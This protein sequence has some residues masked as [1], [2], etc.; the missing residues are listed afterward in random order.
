MRPKLFI[1]AA[2]AV[3]CVLAVSA[4]CEPVEV[5]YGAH[6]QQKLDV[7]VAYPGA[8][9]VVMVH[10]GGFARGDK[11][12][13]YGTM[14]YEHIREVLLAHGFS[15]V[16]VNYRLAADILGSP[17]QHPY[18]FKYPTAHND[19][20]EAVEWVHANGPAYGLSWPVGVVGESA[21]GNLGA[22]LAVTAKTEA[23]AYFDIGGY[24]MLA[25]ASAPVVLQ[26]A[27]NYLGCP[28]DVCPKLWDEASPAARIQVTPPM[29]L[30]HGDNDYVVDFGQ[31]YI[32][33]RAVAEASGGAP[34]AQVTTRIIEGAGHTGLPGFAREDH[35]AEIVAFF[36][37]H[38]D[39]RQAP[40]GTF[41]P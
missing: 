40:G 41:L 14:L 39:T 30:W 23:C 16:A 22:H 21:G 34:A 35:D 9:T 25:Q 18:D 24:P 7:Y 38:C 20:L 10:G 17:P 33:A 13:P 8:P 27:E 1:L 4:S 12:R 26:V 15:V 19:V 6:P 3:S 28:K 11:R 32:L 37:E 2:L 36:S 5:S 31:T 29:L